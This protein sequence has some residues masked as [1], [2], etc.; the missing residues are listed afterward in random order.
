M[1]SPFQC[2]GGAGRVNSLYTFEPD[3]FA[4]TNLTSTVTG[5]PPSPR[6]GSGVAAIGNKIYV[7]G[8]SGFDGELR[9][10]TAPGFWRRVLSG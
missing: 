1:L 6:E 4:W 9:R 3:T 5:T 10:S 8:G 2:L 7:Y